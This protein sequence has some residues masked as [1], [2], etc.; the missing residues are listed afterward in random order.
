METTEDKSAKELPTM[1]IYASI[2]LALATPM[3]PFVM[4][5]F[6]Q[7]QLMQ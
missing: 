4:P 7:H 3:I 5:L 6:H 1:A 2:T